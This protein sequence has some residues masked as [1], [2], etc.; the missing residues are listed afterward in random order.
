[1][2]ASWNEIIEAISGKLV[3][4]KPEGHISGVSTDSR[5]IKPGEL[6]IAL[7]GENFDWH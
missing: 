5:S 6:F 1:M 3:S 2:K 4:G 7:K